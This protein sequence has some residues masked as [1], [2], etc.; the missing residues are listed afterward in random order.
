MP[1][2]TSSSEQAWV[3]AARKQWPDISLDPRVFVA[4]IAKH[5]GQ[6][7]PSFVHAAD[8]YLACACAHAVPGAV[9]AL[10][11]T[12]RDD[13]ARAVRRVDP[14]PAFADDVAQV[15]RAKL[16]VGDAPKITEYAGRSSLRAWLSTAAA[17]AALTLRRNAGARRHEA[18]DSSIRLVA[19]GGDGELA[20]LKRRYGAEFDAALRLA[21]GRID[22][23]HRALLRLH[24]VERLSL[25]R[26]AAVYYVSRATIA[27]RIAAAR[28]ALLDDMDSEL[29]AKLRLSDSELESLRAFV[30][31]AMDVSVTRLLGSSR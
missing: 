11:R 19:D 4:H 5:S 7:G 6:G 16:L 24:F 14:S 21:L 22:A 15:L 26:V 28:R 20:Y 31:S 2:A 8:L 12:F 25:E 9:A 1:A 3:E 18:F 13:V 29:R 27:R 23:N 17:R 30:V 10:E